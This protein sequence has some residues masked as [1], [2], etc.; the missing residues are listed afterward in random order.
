MSAAQ[1]NEKSSLIAKLVKNSRILPWLSQYWIMAFVLGS[2]V[3]LVQ[4]IYVLGYLEKGS[5]ELDQAEYYIAD[6]T[7]PFNDIQKIPSQHWKK[8]SSLKFDNTSSKVWLKIVIPKDYLKKELLLR[9]ND[10]L[11]DS[12]ELLFVSS[13]D[14]NDATVQQQFLL[15]DS[16]EFDKRLFGLPNIVVPVA[17]S[18]NDTILYIAGVSRI[19]IDLSFG[20]WTVDEFIEFNAHQTIFYGLLFGY[21]LALIC[22]SLM[23]V[24]TTKKIEYLWFCFYLIAFYLHV[25]SLSGYAYQFL[26]PNS[27]ALQ[28]AA[29]GITISFAFFFL[30]KFT[31]ILLGK[32][33]KALR[34]TF[35]LFALANLAIALLGLISLSTF[36]VKISMVAISITSLIMPLLCFSIGLK[37]TKA[38]KVSNFLGVVW[39]IMLTVGGLSIIDRLQV[40]P[41]SVDPTFIL[42]VAFHIEALIIGAAL[43]LGYRTS[44][45]ET[46]KNKEAA[47]KDEAEAI[48]AK[49][50][51]L[52][53]QK[54]AQLKLEKQVKAQTLQLEGALNNLSIASNELEKLRNLD[55]LTNLP[56]RLAFEGAINALSKKAIEMGIPLS[57]AVIDIDHFKAVN[58]TYGHLA[59]DDCLRSFSRLLE[60]N[61]N[62]EDYTYCR[63]G[64]EE[65]IVASVIAPAEFEGKLNAFRLSLQALEIQSG[66]GLISITT[67]VGVCSKRMVNANDT[68]KLY[69]KAD[70]N[71]YAAKQK[72]RNLVIASVY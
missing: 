2:I 35:K 66:S 59:G 29:A 33:T 1:A 49:D 40:L 34:L 4:A 27:V 70:E 51:I 48:A 13:E 50:Q 18:N 53:I 39:L 20:L 14:P 17:A 38:S 12:L 26:W 8:S 6:T 47:I 28:N 30:I 25:F 22:Y 60:V 21:I 44:F 23:I 5:F 55:G 32:L 71:L 72:G 15:G 3:L 57:L 10:P 52:A 58:D 7:I 67:S 69:S 31:E 24:A 56:N 64:G 62:L 45:Y 68:R 41:F 9:F 37:G 19:N 63:F 42:I 11:V 65:F 43:I 16:Q 36:Y 54:D 61:F 46:L